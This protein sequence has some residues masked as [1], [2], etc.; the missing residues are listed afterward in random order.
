[1]G[2]KPSA[3]VGR[4]AALG[5]DYTGLNVFSD[6]IIPPPAY[7]LGIAFAAARL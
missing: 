4:G 6:P 3:R 2:N 1:M 5:A 7:G